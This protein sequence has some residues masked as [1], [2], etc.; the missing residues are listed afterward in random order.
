MA[1]RYPL[2]T[3]CPLREM[4]VDRWRRHP[5]LAGYTRNNGLMTPT[6]GVPAVPEWDE[7][8]SGGRPPWDIG[9]P[10]PAILRLADKGLL[11]G[12]LLDSGCGTGEN[13][14]LAAARGAEAV[15]VDFSPVAIGRA[16]DLAAERG[17]TARFEVADVLTLG[18]SAA[19]LELGRFD[20]AIDSGV[21]HVF[22]DADRPRY[23][24][25]LAAVLAPGAT[26]HLMCFSE[27]EPGDWGPRRVRAQEIHEAFTD[28]WE[29]AAIEPDIFEIN[30][31]NI[32]HTGVQAWRAIL[33][34]R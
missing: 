27:R 20:T 5:L 26:L 33:L 6:T 22:E 3:I 15:G 12:R 32:G 21:F 23:A 18:D 31:V 13:T 30:P 24:A 16:R 2:V 4:L 34:R 29:V 9:R 11:A 10:Q 8:Y 14:L 17:L 19:Q 1:S 25:S 28:D 7:S